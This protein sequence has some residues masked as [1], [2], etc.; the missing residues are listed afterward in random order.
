VLG[1]G[2]YYA[3]DRRLDFLTEHP[4]VSGP[5]FGAAVEE[6][7]NLVVCR[8]RRFTPRG[9]YKLQDLILGLVVHMVVV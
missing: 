7:M 1:S 8:S 2:V 9:P 3:A 6:V 4:L 5:F